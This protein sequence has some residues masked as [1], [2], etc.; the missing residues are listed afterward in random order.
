MNP[1]I[2]IVNGQ[3]GSGKGTFVNFIKDYYNN[4]HFHYYSIIDPVKDLAKVI[5]WSGDK[6]D[7]DRLFL[8]NLKTLLDNYNNFSFSRI[9]NKTAGIIDNEKNYS[10]IFIDMREKKDIDR[11]KEIYNY[12]K[13]ILIK[14][15]DY[16]ECG[17]MADDEVFDYDYDIVV[18]NNG[19]IEDLK[20]KALEFTKKELL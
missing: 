1:K 16:R 10:I 19:T 8:Y 11:F 18:E 5:G 15:G 12:T 7:K 2:Y 13:T 17:N 9:V 3:G 20:D 4:I 14:R 6:T